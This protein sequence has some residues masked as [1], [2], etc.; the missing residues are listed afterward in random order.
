MERFYDV[1]LL[2]PESVKDL[3]KF[4]DKGEKVTKNALIK[5]GRDPV[6]EVLQESGRSDAGRKNN[7]E[8]LAE[9]D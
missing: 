7:P 3:Q 1:C 6:A 8:I 9:F 5:A 4:H 2:C